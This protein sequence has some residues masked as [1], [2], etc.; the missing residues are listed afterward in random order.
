MFRL[1]TGQARTDLYGIGKGEAQV[2]D[3]SIM[4]RNNEINRAEEQQNRLYRQKQADER[5]SGVIDSIS[6]LSK[7]AILPREQKMFAQMQDELYNDVKKNI[8]K[9]RNGD[10]QAEIEIMQ[11]ISDIYSKAELS[12]NMREQLE[13]YD[14]MMLQKGYDSYRDKSI[15][16]MNDFAF[17]E[18]H[19]GNYD[20]DPSQ[21]TEKVNYADHVKTKLFPYVK[22][23]ASENKKGL[24]T[25]FTL[26]QAEQLIAED[27]VSDHNRLMQAQEDFEKAENKLGAKTPVEYY[28]RLYGKDLVI[29]GTDTPAEWMVNGGGNDNKQPKVNGRYVTY[30]GGKSR[31]QFEYANTSETP[32]LTIPDPKAKGKTIQVKPLAI[33]YT[34]DKKHANM[35]VTTVPAEGEKGEVIQLDFSTTANIMK[36]KYGLNNVF[37]IPSQDVPEHMNVSYND[38]TK[39]AKKDWSKYKRK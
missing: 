29:N 37:A 26:P 27:V 35:E 38:G 4:Q 10:K 7:L 14:A 24:N 22:G 15:E 34:G 39:T 8:G 12:K 13:K 28:Q 16:Y 30:D 2:L 11:K 6:G 18:E 20:F 32:T 31:F 19:N 21:I 3:L 36:N 17:N 5:E 9:I 33:N 25:T 23:Y 1:D